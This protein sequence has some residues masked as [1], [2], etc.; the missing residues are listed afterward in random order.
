MASDGSGLGL[1]MLL[2]LLIGYFLPG[3]VA[4]MR[5]HSNQNMI[6][7]LNLFLGWTVI[8]WF[9]LLILAF[10]GESK[11]QRETREQQLELLRRL[12]DK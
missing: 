6:A 12:A 9:V 11:A 2:V 10:V 8:G 5:G 3:L 4:S 7:V 1:F